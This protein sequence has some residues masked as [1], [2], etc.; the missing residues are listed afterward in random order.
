MVFAI[1]VMN[2]VIRSAN[3]DRKVILDA[4]KEQEQTE[5]GQVVAE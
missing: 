4:L 2:F 5:L 1:V 3:R